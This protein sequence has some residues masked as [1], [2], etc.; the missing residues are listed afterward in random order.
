MWDLAVHDL[1]IMDFVIGVNP[2]AVSATG[3]SHVRGQPANVAFMTL[4]F[5]REIIAHITSTGCPR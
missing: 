3:L 1:S 4:F 5:D 2:V